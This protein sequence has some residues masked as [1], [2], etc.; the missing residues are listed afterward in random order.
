MGGIAVAQRMLLL[1]AVVSSLA[2][3]AQRVCSKSPPAGAKPFVMWMSQRTGSSWAT[4]LIDS[5][6]DINMRGES[7]NS[8]PDAACFKPMCDFLTSPINL[9]TK[10]VRGFKQKFLFCGDDVHQKMC[11][12]PDGQHD[13][14]D[15]CL[16]PSLNPCVETPNRRCG[17]L[18][19]ITTATSYEIFNNVGAKTICMLRRNAFDTA[20]SVVTHGILVR[21]CGASNLD[22]DSI[23]KCWAKITAQGVHVDATTFAASMRHE[24]R[25]T[26]FQQQQVCEAQ[27]KKSPVFFLHYEDLVDD[28]E[29]TMHDV[30]IF[31]G[32]TP[33]RLTSTMLK[34]NK[35]ASSW[36]TNWDE[37]VAA[38]GNA[39]TISMS[40][41]LTLTKLFH[42][43]RKAF[44]A[45]QDPVQPR[46]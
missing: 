42:F 33:R 34:A 12:E 25:F 41:A 26:R 39:M 5:H 43:V 24:A 11:S 46:G 35:D 7:F 2:P 14:L 20:L 40:S 6:P 9:N 36:I 22:R 17:D 3:Q 32:V 44:H 29:K 19:H 13:A 27:A 10:A 18:A 16:M 23:V 8:C 37:L 31:L 38:A 45:C 30:Q 1:L 28:M 15:R 21:Q 4:S